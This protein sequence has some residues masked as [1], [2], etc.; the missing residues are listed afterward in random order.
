MTTPLVA[1]P[2]FRKRRRQERVEAIWFYA[3]ISPWLVG[4]ILFNAFPSL[5]SSYLSFTLNDPVRWPPV[6][7]GL[8]N[9]NQMIHDWLFWKSL[10]V[11]GE[12]IALE[13]PLSVLCAIVIAVLLNQKIPW[14]SAW[15]SIYYLP[16]ITPAVGTALMWGLVFQ[17]S[18]GLINGTLYSLFHI[19]GPK[20]LV[21]P[22]LV[23]PTFVVMG[24]W[25]FGGSMLLY[26]AA[27]QN[28]P[29]ALYEA[30]RIDGAGILAE[31]RHVTIPA[32]TP[33][34]FFNLILGFV[35]ASETFT[36]AFVVT[37]GG[38]QYASYFYALNI[39]RNAFSYFGTMGY[40]DALTWV[41]F[42]L[43]LAWVG[44]AFKSSRFWVYYE[45][46]NG[47]E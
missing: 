10:S 43:M 4:F 18:F 14:L 2:V 13:V 28:V 46:P 32:L 30:A 24:L 36:A 21:T 12:Y 19:S 37:G 40:A 9:Y 25:Q 5:A 23:M 17:P 33:V 20:W 31:I 22:G 8:A 39:Y 47:R 44:L 42:L 35:R 16:A 41:L 1:Q 7:V 6:W 15:R 38:P 3:L 11:T 45:S 26:L 34:I 27:I 29:T